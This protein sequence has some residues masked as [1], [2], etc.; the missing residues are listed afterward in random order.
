MTVH[1]MGQTCGQV[2]TFTRLLPC[3]AG[4]GVEIVVSLHSTVHT[5][6]QKLET[7]HTTSRV[8]HRAWGL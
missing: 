4:T 1:T 7:L 2:P 5:S 3:A 8:I 6:P